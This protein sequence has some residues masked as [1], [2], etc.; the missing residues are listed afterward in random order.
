VLFP[1]CTPPSLSS[2]STFGKPLLSASASFFVHI[3][4]CHFAIS[5]ILQHSPIQ[6][7][8]IPM[9]NVRLQESQ[10]G[11]RIVQ[12]PPDSIQGRP[13]SSTKSGLKAK[14]THSRVSTSTTKHSYQIQRLDPPLH[15]GP[16]VLEVLSS[17]HSRNQ[18]S[19][20]TAQT[21]KALISSFS[22]TWFDLTIN[23]C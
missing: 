13:A 23:I 4:D 15:L 10:S 3:R 12:S 8:S 7:S 2:S 1:L 20:E 19:H 18:I 6:F 16:R 9:L 17:L 22:T 14:E 21:I 5:A 11:G